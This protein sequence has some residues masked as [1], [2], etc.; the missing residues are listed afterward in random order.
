MPYK[1]TDSILGKNVVIRSLINDA[2]AATVLD[3]LEPEYHQN[4]HVIKR[5]GIDSII[6]N[7]PFLSNV[8]HNFITNAEKA[9]FSYSKDTVFTTG[10]CNAYTTFR[11]ARIENGKK[12]MYNDSVFI[13]STKTCEA[14]YKLVGKYK[15][16]GYIETDSIDSVSFY[17]PDLDSNYAM[18]AI[19]KGLTYV[20]NDT[21]HII[22]LIVPAGYTDFLIQMVDPCIMNCYFPTATDS[23]KNTFDYNTSVPEALPYKLTI[24]TPNGLL[25]INNASHLTICPQKWLRN[26]D[27]LIMEGPCPKTETRPGA[28]ICPDL[29]AGGIGPNIAMLDYNDKS[30]ITIS[31]QAAL[32]LD[33]GSYTRF[34]NNTRINLLANG[35]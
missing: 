30:Q 34:G 5:D 18:G 31:P 24:T 6:I 3:S 29:G 7:N 27:S 19:G 4:I 33:S 35:S 12:L 17:L 9:F 26:N 21:S 15:Y 28:I 20:Y 2:Y 32:I 25:K 11:K 13:K 14:F 10:Y 23:I 22:T 16:Q 8:N 1:C